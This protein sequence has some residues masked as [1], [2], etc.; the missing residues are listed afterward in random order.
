MPDIDKSLGHWERINIRCHC[1]GG[2][3]IWR[4][5]KDAVKCW[6]CHK[7]WQLDKIELST[8][9]IVERVKHD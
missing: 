7:T 2:G 3:I 5:G 4:D 1:G 6:K 8:P 9:V